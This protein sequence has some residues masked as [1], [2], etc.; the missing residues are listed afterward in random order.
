MGHYE[1][2]NAWRTRCAAALFVARSRAETW[3]EDCWATV[4][5]FFAPDA[6]STP[7]TNLRE[8][9]GS[10]RWTRA[11]PALGAATLALAGLI[12]LLA[13]SK[14]IRAH[15]PQMPSRDQIEQARYAA[16]TFDPQGGARLN[17]RT[18]P[19]PG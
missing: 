9:L 8:A 11:G 19:P 6:V 18:A 7:P 12:V 17:N 15:P 2:L 16:E 13:P 10:V 5:G 14:G 4:L 3:L 1:Q